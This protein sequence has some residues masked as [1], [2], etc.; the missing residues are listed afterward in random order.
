MSERDPTEMLDTDLLHRW[1]WPRCITESSELCHQNEDV[2]TEPLPQFLFYSEPHDVTECLTSNL[3]T[4]DGVKSSAALT[5]HYSEL[6]EFS[7]GER[8]S[9]TQYC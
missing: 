9:T 2:H 8:D 6:T 4:T 5:V 1:D 7:L 3:T